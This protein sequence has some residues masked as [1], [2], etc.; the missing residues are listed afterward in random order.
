MVLSAHRRVLLTGVSGYVGGR[1]LRRLEP[2]AVALRCLARRPE[3][4][5]VG[6]QVEVVA[7]DVL[8]RRSL[9]RALEGV[10]TAC[11]LIHSM[12]SRG[13]YRELDRQGAL[14]FA[15]AARA[16]GVAQIVY[17]GG[18]GTEEKLS[19]H[20]SSRHE[21]GRLLRSTGV[22]TLEL[23]ASIVIGPGSASFE[24]VRELVDRLPV[25][26]APHWVETLAQP[27]SIDEVL[28]YLLGA[29]ARPRPLDAI[30]EVGG[31]DQVTYAELMREYAR[32]RGLHRRVV[33]PP[34]L[35][36]R[37][38][39]TLLRALTP[40][41]G[42]VAAAMVESL[43]NE[44]IVTDSS[45]ESG[46]A[47]K[48]RSV[49]WAISRA[50]AEEDDDFAAK[51]WSVE[52]GDEELPRWGG[53]PVGHRLVA[54]RA[55]RVRGDAEQVFAAIE[56]IGGETGWY[57][58][59]GFWRLRG[60]IDAARGGVGLRRGRPSR[61]E[62]R[63]GDEVDFWR[64]ERLD[65]ERLLCLTAEMKLPGRLWLQF[66]VEPAGSAANIRQTTVFDPAGLVGLVYWYL[67][68]PVHRWVFARLLAGIAAAS[69]VPVRS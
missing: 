24:T 61:A 63:I 38:S 48:K 28:G 14:N 19:R 32:Q 54:S 49:S 20:L 33:R 56:R 15:A 59:E 6:P 26:V 21:V 11:Y 29:I 68:Y 46:F 3:R 18:L 9:D 69:E 10:H 23:R 2:E 62:L 34:L 37:A 1:L 4:L 30:V 40:R 50:L 53:V 16:A 27:V 35:T 42:R 51:R 45:S 13:D 66:E 57:G 5:S 52:L 67:L 43:R 60:A 31:S 7:G 22:P 39:R 36:P 55:V 17:L 64:V 65:S 12:E 58:I 8:D 25:I 47:V 44:T 41:Y